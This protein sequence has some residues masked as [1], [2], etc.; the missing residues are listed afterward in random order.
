MKVIINFDRCVPNYWTN[1]EVGKLRDAKKVE[2]NEWNKEVLALAAEGM[3]NVFSK[4]RTDDGL[5]C[6]IIEQVLSV[7]L[8][9]VS[10]VGSNFL[11]VL[12]LTYGPDH[13]MLKIYY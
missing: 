7:I 11:C 1:K 6:I 4:G 9:S 13:E 8:G 3:P 12:A 10:A 5:T 2:L